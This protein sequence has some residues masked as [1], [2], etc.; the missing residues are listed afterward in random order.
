MDASLAVD[1][2]QISEK[3]SPFKVT[4]VGTEKGV[5]NVGSSFFGNCAQ[6]LP[7]NDVHE[8]NKRVVGARVA[9]MRKLD[10]VRVSRRKTCF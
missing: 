4:L 5:A 3:L 2:F 8:C 7:N 10:N 6:Q 9:M 1:W